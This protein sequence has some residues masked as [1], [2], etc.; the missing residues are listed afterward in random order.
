[1][2]SNSNVI[3]I[4]KN[5]DNIKN[6]KYIKEIESM[7]LFKLKSFK[8]ID[9]AIDYLKGINFE[10]TKI[11]ISG[12]FYADFVQAFKENILDMRIAPKII[13]FTY[14]KKKFIEYNKE[15][16]DKN[17]R[18]YNF[19]GIAILF[20]KIKEFLNS[21]TNQKLNIDI[22]K[23][24]EEE[25]LI[26]SNK[27][28][29][30]QLLFEYIDCREKLVLPLFFKSLIDKAS[31]ENMEKYTS[32][33]YNNYSDVSEKIKNLLGS[34]KSIPNIPIEILSKY[35]ARLFSAPS[36]FHSDVNKDLQLN[37]IDKYLPFI[38]TLYEGVKIKSL[39]LASNNILY[40]GTK[41]SNDEI[42][43]L[44]GYIKK[45][46]EFLPSSIVFSKSFLS[47]S[48]DKKVA[49]MFLKTGIN[50]DNNLAKVLFILEKDENLDYNLS[51]HGDIEKISFFP[52][53]KE[54][55]FFPFSSF[56]VKEIKEIIK[57]KEYEI[58]LLYLGK[59]LKDIENDKNISING[60]NIPDSEFKK[61]LCDFGLIKKSEIQKIN[62]SKLY[63][64][65]KQ[66]ETEIKEYRNIIN[67]KLN[68]I[69]KN[70]NIKT[71]NNEN[72]NKIGVKENN[73][74]LLNEFNSIITG[75]VNIGKDDVNKEI[76]IINSY[77][78]AKP[79]ECHIYSSDYYGEDEDNFEEWDDI[80]AKNEFEI[81]NYILIKINDKKINF[82]YQYK[83]EKEGKYKIE[84][85]CKNELKQLNH[86]FY[87]CSNFTSID[88]SG[89]K[90]QK[91]VNMKE[92]FY[93]CNSLSNLNLSN[94]NTQ[95]VTNMKDIF[96]GCNSL[97][98][99]HIITKDNN[100]LE[101]FMSN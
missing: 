57:E 10:E 100:I 24:F 76:Q 36:R 39:P 56:E 99:D 82:S 9:D 96:K 49:E 31:N 51:T 27:S 33:F 2:K 92:M 6:R 80:E 32:S 73:D 54:V 45:K 71:D 35:Y 34:I 93:G 75:I 19:S 83:F 20:S 11:I 3:W 69:K 37:I 65:F 40:R 43:K 50:T 84:Y 5:V 18:F 74:N 79:K 30:T 47:F 17:N 23:E 22:S 98:K 15:Y 28:N 4:D 55:L 53:E 29:Q 81:K 94:L 64:A 52:I 85:H 91:V 70:D 95:K 26:N 90:N 97:K 61:Q 1:M 87:N 8:N 42:I 68:N 58:K 101:N 86:M 59:Y 13:V 16:E 38:K 63:K 7:N 78:N 21:Q 77:E 66:Y 67:K 62:T 25:R 48:K 72:N 12:R 44:R 88:L 14:D 60:V 41:M 46:I 89:F